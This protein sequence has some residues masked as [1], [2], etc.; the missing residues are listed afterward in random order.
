MPLSKFGWRPGLTEQIFAN[1]RFENLQCFNNINVVNETIG[2]L[3]VVYP[4]LEN[5]RSLE[6]KGGR[7][8]N[9]EIISFCP[10]S[11]AVASAG[12]A[13]QRR[14]H[15]LQRTGGKLAF[16]HQR[17]GESLRDP[18]PQTRTVLLV[19]HDLPGVEQI[20]STMKK[21][22]AL[23]RVFGG[24]SGQEIEVFASNHG[25]YRKELQIREPRIL[26]IT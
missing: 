5:A 2:S 19:D 6:T 9:C 10:S 14:H 16:S 24:L 22:K 15:R 20:P 4:A 23:W 25:Y 8:S 7:D 11:W 3:R 1:R 18:R 26:Y 12:G 13:R 17:R 21:K